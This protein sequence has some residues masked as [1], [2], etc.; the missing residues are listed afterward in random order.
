MRG[1]RD[2]AYTPLRR[3][4]FLQA[5]FFIAT[6]AGLPFFSLYFKHTLVT[7]SGQPAL[8][9]I[10]LVFFMHASLGIVS[11]PF[12]G[13]ISDRLKIEN[14]LLTLFSI[15]VTLSAVAVSLPGSWLGAEWSLQL[16]FLL[17]L[18]GFMI[19]GLFVKP[20]LPLIDTQTLHALHERHGTGIQYG[21]IRMFG[22]LGWAISAYLFGLI[23]NRSGQLYLAV[24]GYGVGFVVLALIAAG[25]FRERIEPVP[26]PWK[27]LKD[28]RMFRRFLVFVFFQSLGLL[29]SFTFTSFFMDDVR[30]SYLVIG[31]SIGLSALPEIP[32]M[33]L[34]KR[35]IE[36]L[37]NR[38]MI[39]SGVMLAVLK[40]AFFILIA[41]SGRTLWFIPVQMLHGVG[42]SMM[43]TGEINLIDRQSHKDMLAIY[44]SLFH[45]FHYLASAAGSLFASFIL[46]K[47]G[48]TWLMGLD[49]IILT[50]SAVYFLAAVG[51]HGSFLERADQDA[52][53]LLLK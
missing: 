45:L 53:D 7:P 13:F 6:G 36:R 33:F 24:V 12:A 41:R 9:L 35:L 17:L 31:A 37:G 23:L 44:Q 29:S 5:F 32:I 18:V 28:D 25:G 40:L 27:Y 10:G 30:A 46:R 15:V 14:R 49:G 39:V 4:G 51:G 1:G 50:L 26:I 11:T 34:S 3:A 43:W 20:I 16:R 8:Y 22:S 48:S 19:N 47:L 2:T 42:Y 52:G 38:W 21:R